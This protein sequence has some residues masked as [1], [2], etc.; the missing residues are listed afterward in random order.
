MT[1]GKRSFEYLEFGPADE[2]VIIPVPNAGAANRLSAYGRL[3]GSAGA[4]DVTV[5]GS[6]DSTGTPAVEL[7]TLSLA[8]AIDVIVASTA[9]VYGYLVVEFDG[10]ADPD[11][12]A[13]VYI[14]LI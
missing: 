11:L 3:T 13:E 1:V 10:D 14:S 7:G 9:N 5:S 8:N 12:L 4:A 2:T 6:F